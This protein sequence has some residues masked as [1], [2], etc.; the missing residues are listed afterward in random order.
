MNSKVNTPL[1]ISLS[2]LNN[3]DGCFGYGYGLINAPYSGAC[4]VLQLPYYSSLPNIMDYGAQLIFDVTGINK[5]KYRVMTD[6]VWSEW[7][8]L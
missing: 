5:P 1:N 4:C 3:F 8:D 7:S 2:D 6:S